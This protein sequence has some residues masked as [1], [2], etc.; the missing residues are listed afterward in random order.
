MIYAM[1]AV[2]FLCVVFLFLGIYQMF[3]GDQDLVKNRMEQFVAQQQEAALKS[4]E[5]VLEELDDNP[6]ERT[7]KKKS[8]FQDSDLLKNVGSLITPTGVRDRIQKKLNS[9]DLPLKAVEFGAICFIAT[10]LLMALGFFIFKSILAGFGM[11]TMGIF[12]PQ[13]WLNLKIAGKV[14]RFNDQLLDTLIMMSNGLKAG[15]SFPQAMEMVAKEGGP[16]TSTEFQKTLRESALGVP[17]EEAL[18]NL[19]KRIGS[20]DLD[21]AITVV[22]IQRQIGGNLAEILNNI[23]DVLRDRMKLKG[24]I[25]TLTAQGR[26]SGYLIAVLPFGLGLV[27]YF[28][29]P[30]YITSLWAFRHKVSPDFTFK[31]WYLMIVGFVMLGFGFFAIMKITDI[32]L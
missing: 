29:N 2:V 1:L 22:L 5:R 24:Q 12:L 3:S 8:P 23:A 4:P 27:M 16:P 28:L 26:L 32:D 14:K 21:L 17:L 18:Q 31:G 13:V 11:A 30:D 15:Y 6:E 19:N 9:A 7:K 10:L 25:S 20:E